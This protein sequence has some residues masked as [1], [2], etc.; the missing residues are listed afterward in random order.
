MNNIIKLVPSKKNQPVVSA[1]LFT[2]PNNVAPVDFIKSCFYLPVDV[3]TSD[4]F[5]VE[6]IKL[7][8]GEEFRQFVRSEEAGNW[9]IVPEGARYVMLFAAKQLG[10][11]CRLVK[12]TDKKI[13][14][15]KLWYG[16]KS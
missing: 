3:L 8:T 13:M 5:K 15:V 16:D 4:Q 6:P 12:A 1:D 7:T 10:V 11:S 14:I 2:A 9:L